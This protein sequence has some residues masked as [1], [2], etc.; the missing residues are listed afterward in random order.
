MAEV[1]LDQ[2]ITWLYVVLCQSN[3]NT[4]FC[5]LC[6]SSNTTSAEISILI[7][8]R[9]QPDLFEVLVQDSQTESLYLGSSPPIIPGI[10][11]YED[12]LIAPL[13]I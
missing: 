3:S 7:M 2:F 11:D 10:L 13:T 8:Q 5:V 9:S 12:F 4:V 6:V 1:L